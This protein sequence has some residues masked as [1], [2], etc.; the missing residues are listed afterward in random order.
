MFSCSSSSTRRPIVKSPK[1][2]KSTV[3]TFRI[4]FSETLYTHRLMVPDKD[5][6]QLEILDSAN[7]VSTRTPQVSFLY[8]FCI[9]FVYC[10][11]ATFVIVPLS[12]TFSNEFCPYLF[13]NLIWFYITTCTC[14]LYVSYSLTKDYYRYIKTKCKLPHKLNFSNDASCKKLSFSDSRLCWWWWRCWCWV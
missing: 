1:R 4:Y 5:E 9:I 11:I 13:P 2:S 8:S 14:T 6:I 7:N 3:C 10:S 12:T